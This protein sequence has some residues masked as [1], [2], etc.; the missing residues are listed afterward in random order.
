MHML[1]P[2]DYFIWFLGMALE[3]GVVLCAIYRNSFRRYF[4]LNMYMLLSAL[5]SVGRF[6][7]L[8]HSGWDSLEYRYFYFLSDALLTIALYFALI[9]LYSLLFEELNLEKYVRLGAVLLLGGTAWFSYAVV[10]QSS[11]RILTHFANELSQNLYFVGLILTYLLWAFILKLRETRTRLVQLVLSLGIYFSAYA[12][13]YA[14][15]NLNPGLYSYVAFLWPVIGCVL[16][17][18]WSYAFL[19][20]SED[21]QLAPAQLAVVPR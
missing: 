14:I 4:F 6:L 18:A 11:A 9:S 1:G 12:A 19:R 3:V 21:A 5:A 15:S 2:V 20:L 13:T 7:V 10:N 17:L 8:R 16:P